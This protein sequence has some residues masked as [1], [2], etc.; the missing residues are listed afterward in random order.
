MTPYSYP[1]T[2]DQSFPDVA[3][4][5]RP[6]LEGGLR[7]ESPICLLVAVGKDTTDVGTEDMKEFTRMD[8][9]EST[10]RG[11][12]RRTVKCSIREST[13]S[14]ELFQGTRVNN[15]PGSTQQPLCVM[16]SPVDIMDVKAAEHRYKS[17]TTAKQTISSHPIPYRDSAPPKHN[18][19]PFAEND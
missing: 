12:H 3:N 19:A 11:R 5:K 1:S 16:N 6:K 17:T 8:R 4:D 15:N 18:V 10:Q 7:V 14:R 2:K 9:E 13:E